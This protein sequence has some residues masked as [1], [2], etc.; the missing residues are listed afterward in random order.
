[1]GSYFGIKYDGPAD[2]T[3]LVT[4]IGK[5]LTEETE[6]IELTTPTDYKNE[7]KNH[8][9]ELQKKVGNVIYDNGIYYN[10]FNSKRYN[11][12]WDLFDEK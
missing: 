9:E 7:A 5:Q 12:I 2:L 6:S 10:V 11:Y 3:K 4:H 8:V 1:M